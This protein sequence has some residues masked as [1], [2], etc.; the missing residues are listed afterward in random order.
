MSAQKQIIKGIIPPMIAPLLDTDIL[1]TQGLENLVEHLIAGGV[2]GIFVL[3]TT[4][5]AQHL[6]IKIKAELIQKTATYIRGRVPLLVGITDT[7][8]YESIRIAE[9]AVKNKAAAV[10]AAPPY[11]F[12]LGQPELIEYYQLLADK[13]PLPLYLYNMPS[14]TKTMIE[15]DT[16]E[17]LAKHKN[18]IGLKD[19]SANGIYF[20]KLLTL[21]KD[22]PD[23]GLFVG[24]EEMMASMVLMGAHGG[25]AGGA[26]VYPKIFVDLYEAAAAKDVDKTIALQNKMLQVSQ[27]LYGIGRFGSSYIKGIKTALSLK[28]ICSDFLA[29]PFNLFKEP[30]K[31]KVKKAVELLDKLLA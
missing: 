17:K 13:S 16:V 23:F 26:N 2:N 28:G 9:M 19:S 3:G 8:V 31:E 20:C 30:E 15:V 4:G 1:D 5:E 11:F 27:H 29:Q 21:F 7:S 6:S 12:A 18:I 10:V 24:P 14:H 25:V 22:R